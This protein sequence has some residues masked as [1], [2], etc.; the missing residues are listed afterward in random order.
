MS[1]KM[2]LQD[3]VVA[4]EIDD[5]LSGRSDGAVLLQALYGAVAD[6]PIPERLLA[7]LRQHCHP[8]AATETVPATPRLDAAA[9]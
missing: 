6:E 9:S 7:V 3:L 4:V 5:F 8:V 2:G 1:G